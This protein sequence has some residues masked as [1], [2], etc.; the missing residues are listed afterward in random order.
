MKYAGLDISMSAPSFTIYDDNDGEFCFKTCKSYFLTDTKKHANDILDLNIFADLIPKYNTP[1]ERWDK[2]SNW[3]IDYLKKCD[4]I[5]IE[6]YSFASSSQAAFQIAEHASI[7]KNKIYKNSDIKYTIKAPTEIK[8]FATGKG[9]ANKEFMYDSFTAKT[10]IKL[11]DYFNLTEKQ[12]EPMAGVID[13]Y[14]M[15]EMCYEENKNENR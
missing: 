10:G 1:E 15:C 4:Y 12:W 13:S 3:G 11:R 14:Y 5:L 2:I 7:W 9:N 8:K 6:G